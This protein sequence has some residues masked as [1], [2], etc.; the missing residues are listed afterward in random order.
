MKNCYVALCIFIGFIARTQATEFTGSMLLRYEN[1]KLHVNLSP[2]ERVRL[3][4]SI[5]VSTNFTE[6]WSLSVVGRTGLKNKQNVPAITLHQITEQPS[7]DSDLFISNLYAKGKYQDLTLYIG[8]IPW[9]SSQVTDVFWDRHLNPIGLHVDYS[10]NRQSHFRFASFKPLDG[11]TGTVGHMSVLQF[12]QKV[13]LSVGLLTLSPWL[14]NFHG[15]QGAEFAKQDT[16][17]DHRS[18]R[19]S[20]SLKNGNW[21]LGFDLG[22]ALSKVP[23]FLAADFDNQKTSYAAEI[24]YGNLKAPANYLLQLRYLKVERFA[25]I[26]EFAQNAV[27]RFATS[28]F[29]GWDLRIRRNMSENWWLGSRLSST[30][31]LIGEAEKGTRF[32][33]ETKYRF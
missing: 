33:I 32:R 14:V 29:K 8:K 2:R 1:E 27:S 18:I 13:A 7:G 6:N 30:E 11:A 3:I 23:E 9:K 31:R 21:Q 28:N 15:Q 22:H 20:S 17:Y 19:L 4:G 26:T 25:V 5:G 12:Q 10:L 24:R 16:Q